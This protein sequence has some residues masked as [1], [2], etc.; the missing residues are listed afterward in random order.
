[1]NVS[2][3]DFGQGSEAWATAAGKSSSDTGH[4][5]DGNGSHP[6]PVVVTLTGSVRCALT[7]L[8]LRMLAKPSNV[9]LTF[10][11]TCSCECRG[12]GVVA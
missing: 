9:R 11:I 8:V 7:V 5:T 4:G 1:M 3:S 2:S 10:A 12:A 6:G